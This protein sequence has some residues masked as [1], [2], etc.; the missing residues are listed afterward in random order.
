MRARLDEIVFDCGDPQELARF[1]ASLL[2]G[3]PVRRDADWSYVDPPE[4]PR[5]AF[6]GVSEPKATKNRLHLDL[7]AGDIA[8]ATAEAISSWA[9]WPSVSW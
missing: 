1:W 8:T 4:M 7:L 5:L 3:E 9:R 6:Q 2:G